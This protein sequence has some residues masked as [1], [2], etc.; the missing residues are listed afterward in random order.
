MTSMNN[1]LSYHL[2]RSDPGHQREIGEYRSQYSDVPPVSTLLT[3]I[4]IRTVRRC[5]PHLLHPGERAGTSIVS[6]LSFQ[7]RETTRLDDEV[8]PVS[9][10]NREL[11]TCR[12]SPTIMPGVTVVRLIRGEDVIMHRRE[13]TTTDGSILGVGRLY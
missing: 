3:M 11:P 1:V 7:S 8:H 12:K 9:N 13:R 4:G 5:L 2:I 10:T 6:P